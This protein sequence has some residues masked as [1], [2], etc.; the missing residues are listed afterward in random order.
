[1]KR[2]KVWLPFLSAAN[3][4]GQPELTDE[5]VALDAIVEWQVE[6]SQNPVIHH[7]ECFLCIQ[8]YSGA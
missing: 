7:L 3:L 1:M 6:A 2:E 8:R 5:I 4:V